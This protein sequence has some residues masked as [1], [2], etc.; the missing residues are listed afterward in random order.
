M[1]EQK[2]ET[3][4]AEAPLSPELKEILKKCMDAP[5]YVI[6]VGT[7]RSADGNPMIDFDYRR[8]HLNLE[9]VQQA[10]KAFQKHV[11]DDLDTL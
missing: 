1:D 6:F 4:A 7:L 11:H 8:Y 5:G 10:V 2:E 9:D 3:G